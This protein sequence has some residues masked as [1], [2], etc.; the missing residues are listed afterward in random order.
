M[1]RKLVVSLIAI[2]IVALTLLVAAILWLMMTQNGTRWL[3]N[4]SIALAPGTTT[5][6]NIEGRLVGPLTLS[7]VDYQNNKLVISVQQLTLDWL[8][9]KLLQKT[10]DISQLHLNGLEVSLPPAPASPEDDTPASPL[11]L[12]DINLPLAIQLNDIALNSIHVSQSGNTLLAINEVVLQGGAAQ[13]Q[14]RL[15]VFSVNTPDY[16]VAISGKIQTSQHYPHKL[17]VDWQ[18]KLP[19]YPALSGSGMIQGNIENISIEHRVKTPFQ[20]SLNAQALNPLDKL[21]WQAQLA[22]DNVNTQAIDPSF[23]PFESQVS[24]T[25]NG[26]LETAQAH[27]KLNGTMVEVGAFAAELSL[28]RLAN[29][30]IRIDT[31]TFSVPATNTTVNGKGEWLANDNT[32]QLNAT[33]NWNNFRWPLQGSPAVIS[34]TGNV[35]VDGKLDNYTVEAKMAVRGQQIPD[36]NWQLMASGSDKAATLTSLRGETLDGI[37][38]G[39]GEFS[40][41]PTLT[42]NAQLHGQNINPAKKW[43][44]WPGRIAFAFNSDGQ[45]ENDRVAANARI[46]N[47]SGTLRQYPILV[48]ANTRINDTEVEIQQ[49][50]VKSGKSHLTAQ[51]HLGQS[52]DLAV[53]LKIPNLV[54]LYPDAKGS[55]SITGNARGTQSDPRVNLTIK[56]NDIN[57][58][59]Y[60][61]AAVNGT[62]SGDVLHWNAANLQLKANNIDLAGYQIKTVSASA[63]GTNGQH[64]AHIVAQ[65]SDG[66]LDIKL[67]GRY[68]APT[69]PNTTAQT[70]QGTLQQ[71]DVLSNKFGQWRL[72]QPGPLNVAQQETKIGPWC[73]TADKSTLCIDA[74]QLAQAWTGHLSGTDLDLA[75]LAPLLPPVMAVNGLA[76]L[77]AKARYKDGDAVTAQLDL[78]LPGGKVDYRF[79][80]NNTQSWPYQRGILTAVLDTQGMQSNVKLDFVGGDKVQATLAL[81]KLDVRNINPDRQAISSNAQI[82][83]GDLNKFGP[84]IPG[85]QDLQGK[86]RFKTAIGGT[87]A[88]PQINLDGG[89]SGGAV[90]V[91]SLNITISDIKLAMASDD[92]KRLRY[93]ADARSGEG[94]IRLEGQTLLDASQQWPTEMRIN[95]NVFEVVRTPEARVEISP[96]LGIKT[97]GHNIHV[98]GQVEVPLANLQPKDTSKAV[99]VSDDVTILNES[100]AQPIDD[101]WQIYS[102]VKVILGQQVRFFG[103]DFDGQLGGDI[104]VIDS[105]GKPTSANGELR[106]VEGRYRAYGQRLDIENGKVFYSG[107]PITNPGLDIRATRTVQDVIAGIK[108]RGTVKSPK[109]ELFSE[110]AMEQTE[111]LSYLILGRPMEGSSQEDGQAMAGAAL[112][113]GLAGGDNLARRIGQRFGF[114]ELRIDTAENGD[115]SLLLGRYLSPRLYL[116]YGVGIV[117]AITT[118]NIRYDL[119][120]RLKLIGESGN[121]HG[122]DLIYTIKR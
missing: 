25:A 54:E 33:L 10:V 46:K 118:L 24:L 39:S 94:N 57:L 63:K 22:I 36:G 40:W 12:P 17:N 65:A 41:Q 68:T 82:S 13:D 83:L 4:Q 93:Q 103:Y 74:Q 121:H 122:A 73:W 101:K 70:W 112:A 7:G 2:P 79:S 53:S 86:L 117:D 23:P 115:S 45:Y 72:T 78:A 52:V 3:V 77:D 34:D 110:P 30:A 100:D 89:L 16:Q 81:P 15:D 5:I 64:K 11:E 38:T 105:P 111:A 60:K 66:D 26:T 8:P 107:G 106:V 56:G 67:N 55:V 6:E 71:A 108:I 19:E 48:Q 21:E 18:Y 119:S 113:L 43:A 27:A 35:V 1:K 49:L 109:I 47:I 116:S 61:V 51:G 80:E 28:R 120:E 85:I 58:L 14:S 75:L 99:T 97:E 114:D 32:H 102:N 84:L 95:G 91:T 50:K 29:Q 92:N 87:L 20:A 90:T 31:L 96:N 42:W 88:Q 44:D 62:L 37:I 98:N 9:L 104:T 76:N 69:K 59:D